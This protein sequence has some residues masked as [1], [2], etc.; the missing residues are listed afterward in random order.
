[1][2]KVNSALAA[3]PWVE[4]H[5][6]DFQ[7]KMA[8]IVVTSSDYDQAATVQAVKDLGFGVSVL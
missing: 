3:L 8:T 5:S 6:V 7:N 1:M 2:G 4:E